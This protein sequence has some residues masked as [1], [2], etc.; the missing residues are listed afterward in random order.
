MHSGIRDAGDETGGYTFHGKYVLEAV[1][2]DLLK[3]V[4]HSLKK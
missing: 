4:R 2:E 1:M 3:Q